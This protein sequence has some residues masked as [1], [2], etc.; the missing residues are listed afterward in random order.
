MYVTD[1]LYLFHTL[2]DL[3]GI[4]YRLTENLNRTDPSLKRRKMLKGKE[5][6]MAQESPER[7]E[8]RVTCI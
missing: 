7:S 5:I 6:I 1:L 3:V 4:L 8:T 2:H